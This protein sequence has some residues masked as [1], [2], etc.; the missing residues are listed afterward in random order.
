MRQIYILFVVFFLGFN[1]AKTAS[2]GTMNL[3]IANLCKLAALSV[4][5]KL[6][7]PKGLLYAISLK[8]TGRW[9]KKKKISFSWPWT[10]TSKGKGRY[11]QTKLKALKETEQ[12]SKNGIKNIDV[13]CMQINL[14][15]H[16]KAFKNL[17][18][19]FDPH[20]NTQYAGQFL[21]RLFHSHGSWE[22][23]VERY[24]S[25]DPG[26]GHRYRM[27]VNKLRTINRNIFHSAH[28]LKSAS[29]SQRLNLRFQ[30]KHFRNS[31]GVENSRAEQNKRMRRAFLERKAKVLRRWEKM[32]KKRRTKISSNSS[33]RTS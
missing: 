30:A 16:P 7:L 10:V 19:A 28:T 8:E 22:K 5:V 23:A 14:F 33:P 6:K 24:H 27:T 15:Y 2:A 11:F 26:R 4:E 20:R 32:M 21:K 18:E 29:A 1:S 25:S 17:E 3:P 12:L 9:S 13:G 31:N